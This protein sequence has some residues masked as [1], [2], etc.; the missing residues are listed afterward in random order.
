M[1]NEAVEQCPKGICSNS[2]FSR[3][4]AEGESGVPAQ[5]PRSPR[6]EA[7]ERTRGSRAAFGASLW[8]RWLEA[9]SERSAQRMEAAISSYPIAACLLEATD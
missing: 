7:E 4:V 9:S 5:L 3:S 2:W 6:S 8:T 1:P